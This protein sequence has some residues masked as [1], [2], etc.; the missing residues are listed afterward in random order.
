M[1]EIFEVELDA[2]PVEAG[3]VLR[4]RV[5]VNPDDEKLEKAK[6][7]EVQAVARIHGSGTTETVE[8]QLQR[9]EGPFT[10]SVAVEFEKRLPE[11]PVSWAG[12]YVKVNWTLQA[13]LDVPWA[14]DPKVEVPFRVVPRKR[15]ADQRQAG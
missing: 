9:V 15:R 11:G 3:E 6:A 8:L 10:G 4:G 14:I 1:S 12:R 5:R 2:D 13:S 7:L